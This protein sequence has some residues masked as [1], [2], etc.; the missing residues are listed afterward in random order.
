MWILYVFVVFIFILV[1][2]TDMTTIVKYI[3]A[4]LIAILA[5]LLGWSFTKSIKAIY[6]ALNVL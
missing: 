3:F 1:F 4:V 5:V 2:G 6:I